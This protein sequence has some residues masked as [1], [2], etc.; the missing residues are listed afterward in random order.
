[1]D[2]L[3]KHYI[4]KHADVIY[5]TL[6]VIFF[7]ILLFT[8]AYYQDP[9]GDDVLSKYENTISFYLD[10]SVD[11]IGS[12][13]TT[14]EQIVNAMFRFYNVWSGRVVGY[15]IMLLGG[16]ILQPFNSA[17]MTL[18][19]IL[20]GFICAALIFDSAK[21]PFQHSLVLLIIYIFMFWYNE[22]MG[23]M[24]M[25]VLFSIYG[26]TMLLCYLYIYQIQKI[27][28]LNV[29]IKYR[30]VI[31]MNIFGFITGLTHEILVAIVGGIVLFYLLD[32]V[33]HKDFSHKQILPHI[34]LCI[35]FLISFFAPGNFNRLLQ[36]HDQSIRTTRIFV[37]M[38]S[39]LKAHVYFLK[40]ESYFSMCIM[41]VLIALFIIGFIK[42][43]VKVGLRD[44][45]R[46][47]Y[48][49]NKMF[50]VG[51]FLSIIGWGI[52]P[53]VP[54]YGLV[55]W[56]GIALIFLFRNLTV[57]FGFFSNGKF[58][59]VL[60]ALIIAIILIMN[61]S[62]IRDYRSAT[63]ERRTLIRNAIQDGR[64]EVFVPRY[65]D[66]TSNSITMWG[67][68]NNQENFDT[69]YYIKYYGIHIKVE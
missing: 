53:S 54:S 27:E 67:Y 23:Y 22:A 8:V 52:S 7:S 16:I 60:S 11:E 5:F 12:S 56:L 39:S 26:V 1:M 2:N 51:G 24:L 55:F 13:I 38:L 48:Q 49:N 14:F 65:P 25:W 64:S 17:L 57:M 20:V 62:W 58:N 29:E 32:H 63:I 46:N 28:R 45:I 40:T 69:V 4:V 35:G 41:I 44:A 21:K 18:C 6:V 10:E 31:L 9:I 50:I 59:A 19:Y 61:V 68:R 36:S 47:I 15:F 34:G 37:R 42:L 3:W 33:L 30:Y 66:N 43:S